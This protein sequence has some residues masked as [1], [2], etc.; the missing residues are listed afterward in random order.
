[1]EKGKTKYRVCALLLSLCMLLMLLPVSGL[2]A[3]VPVTFTKVDNSVLPDEVTLGD[4]NL[5]E[6]MDTEVPADDEVVR[7]IILLEE[8]SVLDAGY[9][10]AGLAKNA[11]A[12]AYKEQLILSQ[13]AMIRKIETQ[14]LAGKKLEV[15]AKLT[16][17]VNGISV[18]IPYGDIAD[19][20]QVPGVKE[21][22]LEQIHYPEE[23]AEPDTVTSG[24][25]VNFYTAWADGYT[26]AG[27]LIAIVDTGID[28]DHPS[29]PE[30]GFRYGLATTA[31]KQGKTIEDYDLLT[32]EDVAQILPELNVYEIMGGN[33]TAEDLYTNE[34][35][36]FGFNYIME[37]IEYGC[38]TISGEHGCHVA[39]IAAANTY[40]PTVDADG[41]TYMDKQA[42]GVTGV[43]PDAQVIV[44]KVFSDGWGAYDSDYMLAIEDAIILG[45]DAVNLSLGGV[46]AGVTYGSTTMEELFVTLMASDTVMTNSAGNNGAWADNEINGIGLNRTEDIRTNTGGSPGS[47]TNS[48]AIASVDNIGLTGIVG[49]YNGYIAP[50]NDT[51]DS[52]GAY[53]FQT[54][55]QSE[56]GS[57]TEYPYV[58]LGNPETGEGIYGLESDFENLDLT[59][60]V[61]L[62]SRGNS[63]FFEKAN[64]A[65]EHGAVATVIY[66]NVDGSINMNLT[67]YLYTNPAVSIDKADSDAIFAASV[68]NEETGLWEGTVTISSVA[69]TVYGDTENLTMSSFSS[70][71]CGDKLNLKPEITS[72]GGSIFS[73]V[74][75]GGY[76]IMSGT[77]MS[78]PSAAGSTTVVAQY[79]KENNLAE[80]TGLSVRELAI[81]L[82]MSTSTPMTD[83][84]TGLYYSPRQQG[85]GLT[86][87]YEAV[88]TPAYLLVGEKEGN[89]GKVKL[90]LGDDPSRTGVYSGSFSVNNITD[91]NLVYSFDGSVFT[92]AVETYEDVNYMSKSGYALNPVVDF[93]TDA[94]RIY[95]YDINEDGSVDELDALVLLKVANDTADAL[96]ADDANLYDFDCDGA[97]TT[98]DAQVFLAALKGDTSYLDV[99]AS[100]YV[101]PAGGSIEVSFTI[102]LSDEDKAYFDTYYPN[103]GYV[104]GFLFVNSENGDGNQLSVPVLAF[105]GNWSDASMYEHWTLLEDQYNENATPSYVTDAYT[106]YFSVK[107]KGSTSSSVYYANSWATDDEYI[108]DR[109]AINNRATLYDVTNTLLRNAV[110]KTVTIRNAETGEEYFTKSLGSGTGAYYYTN[111]GYWSGLA[112]TGTIDW[113]LTDSESKR[114]E[115]GTKIEVEIRAVTEYNWDR[116]NG[117]VV[118]E[119]GEG[120]YWTTT[121]TVDNTAPEATSIAATTDSITGERSLKVKVVDN[122]YTA[123]V[124]LLSS[125]G[126][127][128]AR[129]AVNQTE[130]GVEST[131][132]F[133]LSEVYVNDFYVYVIDYAGNANTYAVT[134]GGEIKIPDTN[135][136]LS[137]ALE[138]SDGQWFAD[139][140]VDAQTVTPKTETAGEVSILSTTRAADGTLYAASAET[141]E[142]DGQKYLVSSLYTVNETDYSLT[143]VGETQ[144]VGYTDMTWLPTVNGGSLI[145]SYGSYVWFIDTATGEPLLNWNAASYIGSTNSIM[146]LAYVE[147]QAN[148]TY[149]VVDVYLM[150]DTN[151]IIYQAAFTYD[152]STGQYTVFTPSALVQISNTYGLFYGS[153]MYYED[154]MLYVSALSANGQT[155]YSQLLNADLTA[156]TVWFFDRGQLST[157]PVCIYDAAAKETGEAGEESLNAL[158]PLGAP[159]EVQTVTGDLEIE[160]LPVEELGW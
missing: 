153:S 16:I 111:G 115:E 97:I 129:K 77:S 132:D 15:K 151:G 63:S 118:G 80:R 37:T 67:G 91:E 76:A 135:A 54:L 78:A 48:F 12:M 10:S 46:S 141:I 73:T 26:G 81:A 152:E 72:P 7:A 40:V 133:D 106:N 82:M 17:G 87:V 8:K 123:A 107:F 39:G 109:N 68:K 147:T 128:L 117:V 94:Q 116:E 146:A 51:G 49:N 95:V 25:M 142:E 148:A 36:P 102:T 121:M 20:E 84:N 34:K 3:E 124:L 112:S 83:A 86:Q 144:N 99:T 2:A 137:V 11:S 14:A 157:A 93:E 19:I 21:V 41:D 136:I 119:L 150:M 55:D 44:M 103:G 75:G 114:L 59:G 43:A 126:S 71:G 6:A 24:E 100:T 45:C 140:D 32:L 158:Q 90:E 70:W 35:I 89:D 159:A 23:T 155:L 120:V 145:G 30:E 4:S 5:S 18:S 61:V 92:N 1:M 52:Y 28:R 56:D 42:Q 88:T 29:F 105:Y 66:N 65:V 156:E 57:G 27:G 58:F 113:K 130:L 131:V 160:A 149:G 74:D 127:V 60:K 154:G 138:T 101:V 53:L 125:S 33:I 143:R 69:K 85:S 64:L 79:I 50:F 9:S 122:R 139:L 110:N 22:Y 31:A 98:T 96:D 13:D 108:A 134:V 38:D 47:Y 62:I 104:D